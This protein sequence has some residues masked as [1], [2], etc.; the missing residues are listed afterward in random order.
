VFEH[1]E[2]ELGERG[3]IILL[4]D[5]YAWSVDAFERIHGYLLA[6]N[7]ELLER[8]EELYDVVDDLSFFYTERTGEP[9]SAEAAPAHVDPTMLAARQARLRERTARRCRSLASSF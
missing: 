6:Q 9:A 7:C 3:G 5:T 8:G 2:R 1:R 4:H